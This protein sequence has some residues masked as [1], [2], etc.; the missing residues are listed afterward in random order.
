MEN[1]IQCISET[2]TTSHSVPLVNAPV[3]IDVTETEK[4][5]D[6]KQEITVVGSIEEQEA[7]RST[8]VSTTS[9]QNNTVSQSSSGDIIQMRLQQHNTTS[10]NGDGTNI[11]TS[12]VASGD[13]PIAAQGIV[14][15]VGLQSI[16][17]SRNEN[18]LLRKRAYVPSSDQIETGSDVLEPRK[19]YRGSPMGQV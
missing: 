14:S 9:E 4:Y 5:E 18:E 1:C 7:H 10:G 11:I 19:R 15:Q 17:M 8:P 2:P 12:S 6:R 16:S 3:T 13:V